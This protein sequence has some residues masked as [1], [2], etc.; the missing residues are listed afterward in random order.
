ML[1]NAGRAGHH[2]APPRLAYSL[3]GSS[4]FASNMLTQGFNMLSKRPP[5]LRKRP[6]SRFCGVLDIFLRGCWRAQDLKNTLKHRKYY[7]F[8]SAVL[9]LMRPQSSQKLPKASETHPKHPKTLQRAPLEL[10]RA[11]PRRPRGTLRR[12]RSSPKHP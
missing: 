1:A 11:S 5:S 12:P 8:I 6:P 4:T 7:E 9:L 2:F 10:P 3:K